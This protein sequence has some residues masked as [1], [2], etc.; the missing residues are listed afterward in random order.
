MLATFFKTFVLIFLA[1]LGDKT[2]LAALSAAASNPGARWSIFLGSALAL[3][4]TSLLAVLLGDA[5]SR[6]PGFGKAVKFAAGALFLVFG[7]LT[8]VDAARS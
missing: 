7:I 3:A 1:E 6:L 8:I 5:L 2:Q 4:L